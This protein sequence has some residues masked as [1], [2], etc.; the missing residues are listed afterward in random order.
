VQEVKKDVKEVKEDVKEVKQ[1]VEAVEEKVLEV[2]KEVE[3]T[4]QEAA[5]AV[6]AAVDA[7][8]AAEETKTYV[9]C[10]FDSFTV[11]LDLFDKVE[12][13]KEMQEIRS[14]VNAQ[15]SEMKDFVGQVVKKVHHI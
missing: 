9:G 10:F 12:D 5:K 3:E 4:K 14:Y 6:E 15:I 11:F 13:L 8:K 7:K 1:Q 2:E